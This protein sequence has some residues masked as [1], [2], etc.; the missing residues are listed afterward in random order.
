MK[1]IIS[2][3][4]ALCLA[5]VICILPS[6]SA[7][8]YDSVD[9]N[10]RPDASE[11]DATV[12]VDQETNTY[13]LTLNNKGYYPVWTVNVGKKPKVSSQNN[14]TGVIAEAGTYQVE[15]RMGNRNGISEGSKILE[16]VI[17][18]TIGGDDFT[19]FKYDSEF[20]LWKN[21]EITEVSYWFANNDWGQIGDPSI[22]IEN[23]GFSFILPAEMGTQQWQGQVHI[24]TNLS[25]NSATN[26]DFS[27]FLRA[28][29]DHPGVTVKLQDMTNDE[30]YYCAERVKLEA[31]KGKAFF[32][33][34]V[35]GLD[36]ANIQLCLDFGGGEPGTEVQVSNIVIKD[37]ANDDGTELPA[38]VE[39]DDARN[40]FAGFSVV[41]FTTWF[42]NNDWDSSAITQPA[43][44]F[45][46]EGYDFVMPA[47]VGSQQWQGQVHMWTNVAA[48]E[49]KRY[50]FCCTL[51]CS[52]DAPSVTIKVQKGDSLGDD[53]S[54]DDVFF[55]V[56]VVALKANV[57]Y[58]FFFEDLPGIETSNI[59]ICCDFGGTP[60]GAEVSLSNIHLQEHL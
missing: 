27:I 47:G 56:N 3:I 24:N 54:D 30:V 28:A 53:N 25:T 41:N 6:C 20:N 12:T 60:E 19:G 31:G 48:Y 39:F 37:H 36:I 59:Q 32:L 15:V 1:S 16:I 10:G 51:L 46:S 26:Y 33:S 18:N 50:D 38:S 52:D 9:P 5:A 49:S 11:I 57:P 17:E 34:D 42:A 14:L 8:T 4:W 29:A 44:N 7:D 58:T 40:L 2:S 35:K 23:E 55:N 21:C 45:N 13:T 43:I 22:D